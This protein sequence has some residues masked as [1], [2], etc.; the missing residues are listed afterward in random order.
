MSK[1]GDILL[2]MIHKYLRKRTWKILPT[3]VKLIVSH[4][5]QENAGIIGAALAATPEVGK[6]SKSVNPG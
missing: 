2:E 6:T 5:E 3:D 4:T 1:A